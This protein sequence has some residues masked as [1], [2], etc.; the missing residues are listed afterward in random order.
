MNAINIRQ[1]FEMFDQYLL[2]HKLVDSLQNISFQIFT[3]VLTSNVTPMIQIKIKYCAN[4]ELE[5]KR[6]VSD[7]VC[8]LP[9]AC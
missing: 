6:V 1:I 4:V 8:S 7:K 3:R 2:F 5:A 9:S